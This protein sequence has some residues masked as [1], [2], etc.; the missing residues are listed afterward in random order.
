MCAYVLPD[1]IAGDVECVGRRLA[2]Q[3]RDHPG[4]GWNKLVSIFCH[5]SAHEAEY[6]VLLHTMSHGRIV[7]KGSNLQ[8]ECIE[9]APADHVPN[10]T[11]PRLLETLTY[12]CD[13]VVFVLIMTWV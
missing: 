9:G 4:R 8:L 7:Q 3:A 2:Q 11:P 10:D 13:Q 6:Y 1:G 12:V 5:Q